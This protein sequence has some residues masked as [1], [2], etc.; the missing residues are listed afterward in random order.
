[1]L[2]YLST[3]TTLPFYLEL[4]KMIVLKYILEYAKKEETKKEE[5]KEMGC[6]VN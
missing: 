4:D 3:G 6:D 1:M 2:N 5:N